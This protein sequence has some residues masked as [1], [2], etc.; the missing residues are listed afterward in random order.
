MEI[1]I[2]QME[3]FVHIV[4]SGFNL[5]LAS[6]QLYVSQSA[7][8]QFITNY[9]K[10][11]A[12][13][14]F[15]RKNGR[16]NKL[17]NAGEILYEHSKNILRLSHELEE[18]MTIEANKQKGTVRI[19]VPSLILRVYFSTFFPDLL[20]E[21]TDLHI[22]VVE[23]GSI[24]LRQMLLD[25]EL[26]MAVLLKPT[27]LNNKYYEQQI[28]QIDEMV[29][30]IDSS[31]DLRDKKILQ[32]K[33]ISNYPIA[34][35]YKTFTTQDLVTKKLQKEGIKVHF[36]TTSMSWDYIIEAT[37][38]NKVVAVLPR[39]VKRYISEDNHIYKR[40]KDPIPFEFEICRPI[41]EAYSKPESLLYNG[42]IKLFYEPQ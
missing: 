20:L 31:H 7:L 13:K 9:E 1:D 26:D 11:N 4:E 12:I 41:K 17:T 23:E 36:I 32:W 2:K 40:F 14:L 38:G 39:P 3:Y 28:I 16:L 5:T 29:A 6:K 15:V 24:A 27:N 35:F 22:E 21:N 42:I 18:D 30:F 34:T 33:D 10:D 25:K 19:G 37:K 8:S